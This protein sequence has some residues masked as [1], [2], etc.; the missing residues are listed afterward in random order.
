MIRAETQAEGT[1]ASTL[2]IIPISL[3]ELTQPK[4]NREAR[5]GE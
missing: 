4:I 1:A 2:G 5:S 3:P